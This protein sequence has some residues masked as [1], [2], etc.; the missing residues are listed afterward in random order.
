M[1][2]NLAELAH[3]ALTAAS[4]AGPA[5]SPGGGRSVAGTCVRGDLG[6]A[7]LRHRRKDGLVEWG[8]AWGNNWIVD[9][10]TGTHVVVYTNTTKEGC[11]G[12]FRDEMRDAVFG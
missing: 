8:G 1:Q 7:L 5:P 10:A 4:G 3:A 11:N 2:R 12:P 9:P 6:F